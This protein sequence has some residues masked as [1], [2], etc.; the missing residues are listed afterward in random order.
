MLEDTAVKK[1][2]GQSL[3]KAIESCPPTSFL[4]PG[5]ATSPP[6][7]QRKW[8]A[9][10]MLRRRMQCLKDDGMLRVRKERLQGAAGKAAV[11][12]TDLKNTA[13]ELTSL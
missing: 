12:V 1:L 6:M 8:S 11:V 9:K 10:G 7:L 4:P 13:I 5:T 2:C 3:S